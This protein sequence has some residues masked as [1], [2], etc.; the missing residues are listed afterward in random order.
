[1][2][3]RKFEEITFEDIQA[4]LDN[5]VAESRTLE[6][7]SI[8][9]P[10][11]DKDS[12]KIPFLAEVCALANT[13]GGDIVFGIDEDKG[14]P[15]DLIGLEIDDQDKEILRLE[16]AVKSGI[17]PRIMQLQSKFVESL[18]HKKFLILRIG[19]SWNAP[20]RVSYKDHS[21]FYKR[22][23]AGKYI[24]DIS[25]I[26]SAFLLSEQIQERI[27]GFRNHRVSMLKADNDLPVQM[28]PGGKLSLHLI[29]L[30]SFTENFNYSIEDDR[31]YRHFLPPFSRTGGN[32][33]YNLDGILIY[34]KHEEKTIAYTQFFRNGI[35]E[36]VLSLSWWCNS[37]DNYIDRSYEDDIIKAFKYIELYK[38][39]EIEPPIYFFISL[40]GVKNYR[41]HVNRTSQPL[42][43][44][45]DRD[46]I[47]LPEGLIESLDI[48][49]AK[50]LRP[51]FDMVWNA[52]GF[53]RSYN[54]NEQ[55]EWIGQR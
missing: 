30:T 23:S 7:K 49:P 20:H 54:Y 15:N 44:I 12:E 18:D 8:L 40:I 3:Y 10:K 14:F 21:R 5:E 1:M 51:F 28:Y 24:M 52:Y 31:K 33:R 48:D 39:L 45:L 25:E 35:I 41:F 32:F 2:I 11:A 47:I 38:E 4:L 17:E 6:Y 37:E 29:P 46:D 34:D 22:S 55:G 53:K 43:N 27:R 26:R 19:K 50:I 13:E 16:E 42:K 9:P 36:A